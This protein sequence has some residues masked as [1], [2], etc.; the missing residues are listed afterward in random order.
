MDITKLR[1][2]RIKAALEMPKLKEEVL[3]I[4]KRNLPKI[5]E[6]WETA[7]INFEK[8][9]VK[10]HWAKNSKEAQ[11]IVGK[12]VKGSV[13]K[14]KTNVGREIE[15]KKFLRKQG[16]QVTDTD[17]GDYIVDFMKV[18]AVHPVTPALNVDMK[19]LAK[20]LKCKSDD[21]SIK[22]AIAKKLNH[23]FEKADTGITGAN[24]VSAE[25]GIFLVE[26][27]GNIAKVL[28]QK[29]LIVIT[30]IE[31]MVA[32]HQEAL[33]C[34]TAQSK[35][36]TN[37]MAKLLHIVGGPSGTGDLGTYQTGMHGAEE[38]HLVMI[39]NG[40]SE[41]MGSSSKEILKCINCGLCV[42]TCPVFPKVGLEQSGM[43]GVAIE[44]AK[45]SDDEL[46]EAW[47]CTG[48]GL[49]QKICPVNINL[50]NIAVIIRQ[51]LVSH[52]HQTTNNK[53]MVEN[54]KRTGNSAGKKGKGGGDEVYCC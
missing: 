5:L 26:N 45:A 9:G 4:R 22:N 44:S 51:K 34:V 12:L 25:G 21:K 49:C 13:V 10:V 3:E 33:T 50:H 46:A 6:L 16:V 53:K 14:S 30:T 42:L 35:F 41:L 7:K 28:T 1:A 43:R 32:N 29:N 11:K 37:R 15:I 19:K 47:K 8:N 31:K 48:C 52:G 38:M 39:D 18:P 40:R 36:A 2:E 23:A 24:F 17:C 54:V 27:E 20:Q